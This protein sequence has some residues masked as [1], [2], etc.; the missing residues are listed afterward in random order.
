MKYLRLVCEKCGGKPE[1]KRYRNDMI[2]VCY[3]IT[4]PSCGHEKLACGIDPEEVKK[5]VTAMWNYRA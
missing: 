2:S 4:C 1:L 5:H 3:R